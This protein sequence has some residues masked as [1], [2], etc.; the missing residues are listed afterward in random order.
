MKALL[1]ALLVVLLT[2]CGGPN[3]EFAPP[4]CHYEPAYIKELR[5][6]CHPLGNDPCA[7][8]TTNEY[9]YKAANAVCE[10]E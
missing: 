6:E 1:P 7:Y 8:V 9:T 5:R 4:A 3:Y 10:G 2:G